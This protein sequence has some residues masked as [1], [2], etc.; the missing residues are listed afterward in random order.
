[1]N[2]EGLAVHFDTV[3]MLTWSDWWTEPRSNR[4]HY[5]TRFA[6]QLPT[7]FLQHNYEQQHEL[8]VTPSGIH[9]LDIVEASCGIT[10]RQVDDVR[11]LIRA[12]GFRRTLLWIYDSLNYE[13]L[14]DA[15]PRAFRVYH[16]TEDYLLETK[17]WSLDSDYVRESVLGLLGKVDYVVACSDGV[18]RS[19]RERGHYEGPLAV[20]QNGCDAEFFADV[21]SRTSL[22]PA[23]RV[24]L[25]QGG[26]N[27]RLDYELLILLVQTMPDWDFQF[28]GR[29]IESDGWLALSSQPNV[30][31]LGELDA[32]ALGEVMR[33]AT[34]GM[35]PFIQDRWIENSWPLKAYEYVAC[36]LPVV[37]VPI[38]A[39][40]AEP[41]LFT[42]ARTARE[43]KQAILDAASARDDARRL[44]CC[45]V[46]AEA[47]SYD[48]RF[49]AMSQGLA[50][51]WTRLA[52]SP[53]KLRVAILYD[54][55]GSLHV[56]TIR[57]HLEAFEKY[58]RHDVTFISATQAFWQRA[59]DELDSVL[60]FGVLDVLIVHYSIRTSVAGHLDEGVAR[61]VERFGGLKILFIQ[62]EYDNVEMSRRAIERLGFDVVYTCVPPTGLDY[63]YPAYRFP[64]TEFLPTLT[65]YVPEAS[66]IE[67][68]ALPLE[69]RQTL[70]AYRGRKLPHIY[71]ELGQE[72]YQIGVEMKRIAV[73]RGLPVDIEV[74]DDKRIYSTDWYKFLGR[75]RATLGTES[76]SNVFDIDGSLL[77]RIRKHIEDSPAGDE[78]NLAK[79]MLAP[80]EGRVRMNQVSPK[81]FEAIRLRTA[82]VLFEGEYSGVVQ[83]YLHYIP[84][85]KD[86]SNIEEVLGMLHDKESLEAMTSRA[87]ADVVASGRYSYASFVANVDRDINARICR[88]APR[89]RLLGPWWWV[90]SRGAMTEALPAMPLGLWKGFHPSGRP[91]FIKEMLS[92]GS[93][94][95][96]TTT[97]AAASDD[98]IEAQNDLGAS[99]RNKLQSCRAGGARFLLR[100]VYHHRQL[101]APLFLVVKGSWRALPSPLRERVNPAVWKLLNVLEAEWRNLESK[102]AE[103]CGQGARGGPETRSWR[104]W[105]RIRIFFLACVR[106]AGRMRARMC[107]E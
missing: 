100:F 30:H 99:I 64:A 60:D 85:K 26:I 92:P 86:F 96:N 52:A 19:C 15:L 28:C 71:G 68:Y 67:D 79:E 36:G 59:P 70:I 87:Y 105:Q 40:E 47:N 13:L 46:A 106:I 41:A 3:V 49:L 6:K 93:L 69:Q 76:G 102:G 74:D 91:L 58:S 104:P 18:A 32:R 42:F 27:Q 77:S 37:T 16:A 54:G 89:T 65:G 53:R 51:V 25:Y 88:P 56:S 80:F 12:R 38:E 78:A 35:I 33:G 94:D 103:T 34:V 90:T 1:M 72:K 24:A 97:I 48:R 55:T 5:A 44:R 66:D 31:Y 84:L 22:A 39:L 50:T 4:Y 20:V 107:R 21:V 83:P 23:Q 63:V 2:A 10:A 17:G 75:A 101:S 8:K 29:V 82:L 14:I 62:D 11:M 7:L 57:E 95:P 73:A 9:N 43:F 98:R 45:A 61:A 81:I